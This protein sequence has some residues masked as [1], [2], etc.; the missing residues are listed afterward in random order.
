VSQTYKLEA[1]RQECAQIKDTQK[2]S[3]LGPKVSRRKGKVLQGLRIRHVSNCSVES[4][5]ESTLGQRG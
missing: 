4:N 5:M 1:P 3:L 2:K